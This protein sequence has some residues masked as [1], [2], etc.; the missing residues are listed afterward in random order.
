MVDQYAPAPAQG[1]PRWMEREIQAAEFVLLVCTETYLRRVEGREQ[2]GKGRG[3]VW[4][5]NLIYN[6]LY[7][8]DADVQKFIP[9]LFKKEE[10]SSIP[11]PLRG[12]NNYRVDTD[13]GYEDL[14]RHLTNQPRHQMPGIGKRIALPQKEPQSFPSSSAIKAEAKQPSS[15]DQ[16][17][18]QQMIKQVRLDWITGVLDQSLYKIAR[19]ELGLTDRSDFVEQP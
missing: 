2:P 11:L 8:E 9:V 14:C 1:W 17:H 12:L 7:P 18:R 10:P 3:V 13:E 4:E 16:R 15:L 19:I 6:L 5:V